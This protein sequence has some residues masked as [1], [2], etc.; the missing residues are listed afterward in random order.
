[1][2]DAE[3]LGAD[4]RAARESR[5]LTL[6]QVEQQTRIRAYYLEALESGTFDVLPSPVQGKGF[7]RNYARVLGLDPEVMAARFDAALNQRGRRSQLRP[8]QAAPSVMVDPPRVLPT[9]SEPSAPLP[10]ISAYSNRPE[11]LP[12]SS[13]ARTARRRRTPP[14]GEATT[15][16]LVGAEARRQ[17]NR[18]TTLGTIAILVIGLLSLFGLVGYALYV[19]P[20]ND[21]LLL[22]PSLSTNS[23]VI[24]ATVNPNVTL[25]TT[26]LP[27]STP[28]PARPTPL[29]NPSTLQAANGSNSD[30]QINV[31]ISV[32]RRVALTIYAD[33]KVVASGVFGPE[34]VLQY[35]A[36]T[37]VRVVCGNADAI[38]VT[39]NGQVVAELGQSQQAI[40]RTFTGK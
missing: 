32:K 26:T 20:S 4:L 25:D 15:A 2:R 30:G 11:V 13:T 6:A 40:D 8:P 9:R 14:R 7:L 22:T 1:M 29:P 27:N 5:E 19:P 35:Q 3:A 28:S 37:G 17:R 16:A 39:V 12:T 18:N 34:N 31:T 36:T 38:E 10:D 33:G 24:E 23:G 21:A